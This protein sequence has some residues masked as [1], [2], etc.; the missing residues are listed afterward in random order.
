MTEE[1]G[2]ELLCACKGAIWDGKAS[3][4]LALQESCAPPHVHGQLQESRGSPLAV[5]HVCSDRGSRGLAAGHRNRPVEVMLQ[6]EHA[7][8]ALTYLIIL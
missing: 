3:W 2:S 1:G 6:H 8:V 5:P 4:M 7:A